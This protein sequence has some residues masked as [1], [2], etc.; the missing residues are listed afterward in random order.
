MFTAKLVLKRD[1]LNLPI[2][3]EV[4]DLIDR[5]AK[6]G[7]FAGWPACRGA[8]KRQNYETNPFQ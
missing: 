4:R 5:A 3:A 2:K 8:K 1:T 6:A 7:F